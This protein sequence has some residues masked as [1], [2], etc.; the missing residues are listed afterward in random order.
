MFATEAEAAV[1]DAHQSRDDVSIA[2]EGDDELATARG[3]ALGLALGTASLIA[4][5]VATWW[6][7]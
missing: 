2:V 5:G 7:L 4:I 3:F 1:L 6:A